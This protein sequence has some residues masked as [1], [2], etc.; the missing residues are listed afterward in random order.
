MSMRAAVIINPVAGAGRARDVEKQVDLAWRVLKTHSPHAEVSVTERPGHA[1]EIARDVA[2]RGLTPIVV[3]GGD[4]TVNEVVAA[5]ADQDV[6]L[7]IVPGGSGNGLAR[8]LGLDRRPERALVTALAGRDRY[9]D[10]GELGGR[11]FGN[12]AGIGF[13]AHVARRFNARPVR[14]VRAYVTTVLRELIQYRAA[15]YTIV[16][17]DDTI[18]RRALIVAL[19]NSRQYGSGAVIASGARLDAGTL[20]L[21]VVD[22]RSVAVSLWEARRLFSATLHRARGVMTR[23]IRTL[24]V[25]SNELICFHVDGEAVLGSSTLT[26]RVHPASLRVRVQ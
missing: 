11:R 22:A 25:S 4:G 15:E 23:T 8:E 3:W 13:D 18:R 5:V 17:D 20:Q 24:T 26:A 9:I 7:G 14:G 16:F 12:V 21:V 1:G 2:A 10:V 6:S 19:A